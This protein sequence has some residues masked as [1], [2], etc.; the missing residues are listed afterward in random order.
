MC[1]VRMWN[2]SDM[3]GGRSDTTSAARPPAVFAPSERDRRIVALARRKLEGHERVDLD[4]A[5]RALREAVEETIPAGRIWL[6]GSTSHGPII[7]SILS[8]VGIAAWEDEVALVRV[9]DG[10]ST[11]LGRFSP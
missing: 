3:H 6:L 5:V 9:H 4:E 7:G 11:W 10:R 1:E 2:V 8:G